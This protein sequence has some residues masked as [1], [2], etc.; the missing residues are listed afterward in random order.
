MARIIA[1]RAYADRIS[2]SN[3]QSTKRSDFFFRRSFATKMAYVRVSI[4]VAYS[5]PAGIDG[6][7]SVNEIDRSCERQRVK[8]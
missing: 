3:L 5:M 8:R 7:T 1:A 6:D 4:R 2:I